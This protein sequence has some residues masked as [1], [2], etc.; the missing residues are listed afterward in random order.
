MLEFIRAGGD[1]IN[2]MGMGG[3]NSQMEPFTM[4]YGIMGLFRTLDRCSTK[5]ES[6]MRVSG[7]P[8]GFMVLVFLPG[9]ME[10]STT[11]NS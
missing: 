2:L 3:A 7:K 5:V 8:T 1:T 11:A 6:T 10:S 9:Q 4:G